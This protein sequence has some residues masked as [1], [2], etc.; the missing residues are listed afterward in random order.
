MG[1]LFHVWKESVP[2][3]C[4]GRS[5]DKN[6][7]HIDR[8]LLNGSTSHFLGMFLTFI[9]VLL[10]LVPRMMD[11][12]V[13]KLFENGGIQ[14]SEGRHWGYIMCFGAGGLRLMSF[15]VTNYSE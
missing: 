7:S 14:S 2:L 8:S 11:R 5:E 15:I 4:W 9:I 6:E 1:L 12:E 3:I 10:E 13:I